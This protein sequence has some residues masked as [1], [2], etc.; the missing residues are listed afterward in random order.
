MPSNSIPYHKI[1]YLRSREH[2]PLHPPI[3]SRLRARSSLDQDSLWR[4]FPLDDG[5]ARRAGLA[6]LEHSPTVRSAFRKC[7]VASHRLSARKETGG[8]LSC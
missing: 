5:P 3:W 1:V 2:S 4:G 6:E 8:L 7:R